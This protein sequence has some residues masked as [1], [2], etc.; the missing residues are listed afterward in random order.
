MQVY[1]PV[2]DI[3][4]T[5]TSNSLIVTGLYV[6][7][8]SHTSD[9]DKVVALSGTQ[10]DHCAKCTIAHQYR[11]QTTTHTFYVHHSTE[12]SSRQPYVN[13]NILYSSLFYHL[14]TIL[15]KTIRF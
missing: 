13:S 11:P 12:P 14:A 4:I 5:L 15:T 3:R 8:N 10:T 9:V 1:S 2:Q 7:I 6:T